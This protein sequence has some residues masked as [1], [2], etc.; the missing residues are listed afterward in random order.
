MK[1]IQTLERKAYKS[2]FRKFPSG[3]KNEKRR[4]KNLKKK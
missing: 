1:E 2:P 3:G 4:E